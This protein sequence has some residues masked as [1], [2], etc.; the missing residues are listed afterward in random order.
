MP[1]RT[2]QS[3]AAQLAGFF[4]VQG[5]PAGLRGGGDAIH[6]TD[7]PDNEAFPSAGLGR[8]AATGGAAASGPDAED[9][10]NPDPAIR[11]QHSPRI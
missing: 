10:T 11:K 2:I 1:I 3:L 5:D 6:G 9:E 4:E 8:G 7:H